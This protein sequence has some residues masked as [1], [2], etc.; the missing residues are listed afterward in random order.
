MVY[1]VSIYMLYLPYDGELK[2]YS[3]D[4]AVASFSVMATRAVLR[5]LVASS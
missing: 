1:H 3:T 5:S 2:M 4:V